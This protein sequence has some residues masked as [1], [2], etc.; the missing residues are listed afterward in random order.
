MALTARV[1]K[2]IPEINELLEL[3]WGVQIRHDSNPSL[4]SQF[5]L[6]G[7]V[8]HFV[9]S[10]FLNLPWILPFCW[11]SLVNALSICPHLANNYVI[12]PIFHLNTNRSLFALFEPDGA[13]GLGVMQDG[14]GSGE[15][16]QIQL[17]MLLLH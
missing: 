11:S 9:I 16:N 13:T 4:I 6:H 1:L 3:Q 10:I 8:L 2:Q 5:E 12:F 7:P 15:H 17:T 14:E